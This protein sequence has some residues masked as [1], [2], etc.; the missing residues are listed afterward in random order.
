MCIEVYLFMLQLDPKHNFLF[1]WIAS[2]ALSTLPGS[3]KQPTAT[4]PSDGN[5]VPPAPVKT[6]VPVPEE[7]L[8]VFCVPAETA[9]KSMVLNPTNY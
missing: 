3:K 7:L 4:A 2:P 1:P 9:V 6:P 8:R 5:D